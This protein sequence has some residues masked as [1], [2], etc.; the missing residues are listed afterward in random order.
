M[1]IEKNCAGINARLIW[2]T[3]TPLFSNRSKQSNIISLSNEQQVVNDPKEVAS[4]FKECF[5]T[6]ADAIGVPHPVNEDDDVMDLL[7]GHKNNNSKS[8]DSA[9]YAT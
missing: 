2:D 3:V 7:K 9:K 8:I 6:I 1:F 4:I 5:T